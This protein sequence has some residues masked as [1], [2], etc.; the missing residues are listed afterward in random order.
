MIQYEIDDRVFDDVGKASAHAI[1]KAIAD[2]PV[3]LDVIVYSEEDAKAYG[4]DEA[5]ERY[6][7][8]PDAS[9]FDR[10]I[11]KAESLGMVP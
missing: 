2:K 6:R 3:Y 7:E 8:D 4:G 1:A 5:A 9:V 10:I 11:I